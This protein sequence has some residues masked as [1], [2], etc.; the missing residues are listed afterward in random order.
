MRDTNIEKKARMIYNFHSMIVDISNYINELSSQNKDDYKGL[1]EN[2]NKRRVTFLFFLIL[3]MIR[4]K[5]NNTLIRQN[6]RMLRSVGAYPIKNKVY[7]GNYSM[8]YA[9]LNYLVNREYLLYSSASAFR[10]INRNN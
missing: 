5:M 4:A 2:L 10:I 9:V 7:P 1:L 3:K 6:L 8:K